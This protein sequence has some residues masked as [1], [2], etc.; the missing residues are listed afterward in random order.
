M[1][2]GF[3]LSLLTCFCWIVAVCGLREEEHPGG[4]PI[5]GELGSDGGTVP[6]GGEEEGRGLPLLQ[7]GGPV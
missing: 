6:D 5:Q 2:T 7:A 4:W 1:Q 3:A